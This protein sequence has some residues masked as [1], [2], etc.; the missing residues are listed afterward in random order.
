MT[1][2]IDDVT[3]HEWE[4]TVLHHLDSIVWIARRMWRQ[5]P[6][7]RT[8]IGTPDDAIQSALL[9]IWRYRRRY[10]HADS[11]MCINSYLIQCAKRGV[12]AAVSTASRRSKAGH[13]QVVLLP[14]DYLERGNRVH[15]DVS[16]DVLNRL[17]VAQALQVITPR[18]RQ[19]LGMFYGLD[20]N[21]EH[22]PDQIAA[23]IGITVEWVWQIL[24]EGRRRMATNFKFTRD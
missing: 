7:I 2:R 11:A 24:H 16:H 8:V 19:V 15:D 12:W 3:D 17:E 13:P 6:F 9:W 20:G 21:D 23:A 1:V 5:S 18:Q 14:D 10:L 22:S 4:R